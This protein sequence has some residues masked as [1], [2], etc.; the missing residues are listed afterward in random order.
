LKRLSG[1]HVMV[2]IRET[3]VEIFN[4]FSLVLVVLGSQVFI[5]FCS[6]WLYFV[7]IRTY[8][9]ACTILALKSQDKIIMGVPHFVLSL[10]DFLTLHHLDNGAI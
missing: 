4:I 6:N 9:L 1:Q 2:S 8:G 3:E 10:F 5:L 7:S